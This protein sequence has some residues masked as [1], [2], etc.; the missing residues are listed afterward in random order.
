MRCAQPRHAGR[1]DVTR[2]VYV[3]R[4][5]RLD[6]GCPSC[7]DEFLHCMYPARKLLVISQGTG[8]H[9][10]ISPAHIRDIRQRRVA[11]DLSHVWRDRKGLGGSM[12]Y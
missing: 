9:Y 4:E 11:P 5:G 3:H 7:M 2:L 12:R 1:R 8:K 6:K 10:N